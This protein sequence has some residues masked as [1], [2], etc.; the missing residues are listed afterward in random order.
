MRVKNAAHGDVQWY[1]VPRND[2]IRTEC[3]QSNGDS[4]TVETDVV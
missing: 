1:R 4:G 2:G 3:V